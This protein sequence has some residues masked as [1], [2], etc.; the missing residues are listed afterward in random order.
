ME[1]KK[2]MSI[3]QGLMIGIA[4]GAL[5]FMSKKENRKKVKNTARKLAEFNA[6]DKIVEIKSLTPSVMK[7]LK[8][9]KES[10]KVIH[11]KVESFEREELKTEENLG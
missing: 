8:E 11:D 1:T 2:N 5:I 10:T 6:V 7:V 4:A 9:A 3:T